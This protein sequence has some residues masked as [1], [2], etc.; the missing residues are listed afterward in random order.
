MQALQSVERG[1]TVL[2]FAVPN[3]QET[4]AIDFNPFWRNDISLK[5]SYGAAPADNAQALELILTHRVVVDDMITHKFGLKDINK[6]FNTA[7]QGKQC[8]KVIIKP[9]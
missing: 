9:H 7:G 5:T 2:F 3:P 6:A 4:I 8:I 1:G